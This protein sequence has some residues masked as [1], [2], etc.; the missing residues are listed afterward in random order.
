MIADT[1]DY[2]QWKLGQRATGLIFS[3]GTAVTKIGWSIGPA[4]SLWLLD[5]Y[6]FVANQDQ[7]PETIHG[8][9]L[10]MSLIP[11]GLTLLAAGVTMLYPINGRM[12]K[13][14]EAAI[15]AEEKAL[16]GA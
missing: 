3:T 1:A 5:S 8:L 11:A 14:M 15:I 2:G 7:T 10:I 9:H 6:G 12:E 4:V 13:E 16:K